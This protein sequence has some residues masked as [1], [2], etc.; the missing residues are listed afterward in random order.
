MGF[1]S[2]DMLEFQV[3]TNCTILH[4]LVSDAPKVFEIPAGF[5]GS[6]LSKSARYPCL[7]GETAVLVTDDKK[8]DYVVAVPVGNVVKFEYESDPATGDAVMKRYR[9]C[10]VWIGEKD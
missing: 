10:V 9:G 7:P 5:V 2:G 1:K 4:T 6:A 3:K 8:N